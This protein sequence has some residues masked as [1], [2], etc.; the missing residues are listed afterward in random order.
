MIAEVEYRSKRSSPKISGAAEDIVFS[1]LG[2]DSD[3]KIILVDSGK[4]ALAIVLDFF[5][6]NGQITSEKNELL[7]PQ[8]I[9]SWVYNII[10]KKCLPVNFP[11]KETAGIMIYHQY[12]Y[13]QN[14][15]QLLAESKRN[16]WFVIEDCAHSIK[17]FS[18]D[19]RLGLIGDAGIFSFSKFFPSQMGGAIVTK[20]KDLAKFAHAQ[21]TRH[22]SWTS[23][24]AYWSK[25]L[26]TSNSLPSGLRKKA[27][28]IVE[29][30]YNTY[31]SGTQITKRVLEIVAQELAQGSLAIRKEN[32]AY[33]ANEL[34]CS[35]LI[36]PAANTD[37]TPYVLPLFRDGSDLRHL[38]DRLRK[39]NIDAGIYLFDSAQNMLNPVFKPC[40]RLPVHPGITPKI[41]EQ[42]VKVVNH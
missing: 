30:S 28:V 13:P 4:A 6:K 11:H 15:H 24:A 1:G 3:T 8:W 36:E 38:Q 14:M 5:Q 42:I 10:L 41:R 23:S 26:S 39:I 16:N 34:P 29:M 35:G 33:F 40:L 31:D 22:L 20:R 37:I 18:N 2:L 19:Q 32:A 25:W 17:S 27:N 21:A 7:T 12:G 9:G